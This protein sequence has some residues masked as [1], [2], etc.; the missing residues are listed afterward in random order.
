MYDNG[1]FY[2]ALTDVGTNNVDWADRRE[3]VSECVMR[4]R[5]IFSCVLLS[6]ISTSGCADFRCTYIRRNREAVLRDELFHIRIA[7][8]NYTLEKEH[9]GASQ[10]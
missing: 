10:R 7:I 4:Y 1:V 5:L 2:Q 9:G 8:Q 3:N 6:V